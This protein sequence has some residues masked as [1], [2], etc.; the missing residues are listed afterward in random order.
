MNILHSGRG[1]V[2]AEAEAKKIQKN[3]KKV[4]DFRNQRSYN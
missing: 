2:K 3:T 1:E 4:V